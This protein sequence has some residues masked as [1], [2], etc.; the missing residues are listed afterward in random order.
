MVP[1]FYDHFNIFK[2]KEV[3]SFLLSAQ[4]DSADEW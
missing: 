2:R 4:G 3:I 1:L